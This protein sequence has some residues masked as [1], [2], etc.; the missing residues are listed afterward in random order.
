MGLQTVKDN[1]HI[2][3]RTMIFLILAL[4]IGAGVLFRQYILWNARALMNADTRIIQDGNGLYFAQ[5]KAGFFGGWRF[6]NIRGVMASFDEGGD[7]VGKDSDA[8]KL[9]KGFHRGLEGRVNSKIIHVVDHR[10]A[11]PDS[12]QV[13]GLKRELAKLRGEKPEPPAV[14]S[15]Y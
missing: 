15:S 10:P 9:L 6:V 7:P 8:E 3:N 1:I 4:V 2:R 14:T 5:V 11:R 13:E 12:A